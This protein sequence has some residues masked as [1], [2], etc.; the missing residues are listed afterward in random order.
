RTLSDTPPKMGRCRRGF[1]AWPRA[2]PENDRAR[3]AG[4]RLPPV[5]PAGARLLGEPKPGGPRTE[6]APGLVRPGLG[7][8]RPPHLSLVARSVRASDQSLGP[9]GFSSARAILRGERS[10]L[11]CPDRRAAGRRDHHL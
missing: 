7:E 4:R 9:A 2:Y 3:G 8:P 1:R 6:T 10:R 11:G 5:F